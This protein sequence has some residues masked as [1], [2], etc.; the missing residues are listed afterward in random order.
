MVHLYTYIKSNGLEQNIIS[1]IKHATQRSSDLISIQTHIATLVVYPII[2]LYLHN[3]VGFI[4]P[5]WYICSYPQYNHHCWQPHS[6]SWYPSSHQKHPLPSGNQTWR[7][8]KFS[9]YRWFSQQT[10]PPWLGHRDFPVK[11]SPFF[12]QRVRLKN[13]LRESLVFFMIFMVKTC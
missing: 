8:V 3:M 10:K 4:S 9:I 1:L 6:Y 13:L 7:A 5:S 2:H 11:S 12:Y